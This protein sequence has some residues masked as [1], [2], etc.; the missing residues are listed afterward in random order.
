MNE[1]RTILA[2]HDDFKNKKC[3]VDTVLTCCGHTCA[4]I[5]KFHCDLNL[6]ERVW[7]QQ[8]IHEGTL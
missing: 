7:S 2:G 3:H 5:P 6:I 1:M 8:A 4:F